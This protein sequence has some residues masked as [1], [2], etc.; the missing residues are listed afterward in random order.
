MRL[1]EAD[2]SRALESISQ[3]A[4][5]GRG[6]PPRRRGADGTAEALRRRAGRRKDSNDLANLGRVAHEL[7]FGA[8]MIERLVGR[9]GASLS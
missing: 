8:V 5:R 3:F 1:S 6:G 9:L 2:L 4:R 7:E